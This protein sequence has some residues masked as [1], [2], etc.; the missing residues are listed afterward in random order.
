MPPASR[1]DFKKCQDKTIHLI[2]S[3]V[4]PKLFTY[5]QQRHPIGQILGKQPYSNSVIHTAPSQDVIKFTETKQTNQ[6]SISNESIPESM[7]SAPFTLS[8]QPHELR[9]PSLRNKNFQPRPKQTN[10]K[11]EPPPNVEGN[12]VNE[13]NFVKSL[14]RSFPE[15]FSKDDYDVGKYPQEKLNFKLKA[16]SK[17]YFAKA[18]PIYPLNRDRAYALLDRLLEAGIIQQSKNH[19]YGSPNFFL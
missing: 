19:H 16:G 13:I 12:D 15:S 1:K 14:F 7:S 4:N 8:T 5:D 18:Y 6:D 11:S 3:I 9:V 2:D 17:S 10:Q